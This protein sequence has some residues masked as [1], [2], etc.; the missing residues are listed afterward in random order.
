[1]IDEV[2]RERGAADHRARRADDVA[3]LRRSASRARISA[4]TRR[5][6]SRCSRSLD[7]RGIRRAGRRR[8]RPGW[9]IRDGR[10]A[11]S[12]RRLAD[13]RE[14]LLDAAHNPAGA[15]ALASYLTDAGGGAAAARVRRDARQGRR[16][17]CSRALLPAVEPPRRHARVERALGRSGR[18]GATGARDRAGAADRDRAG[19]RRRARRRVARSRRASS[20]PDRSSC[21]ATCMKSVDGT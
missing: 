4:R 19:A 13:G 7:A 11:S 1:M 6:P 10:A 21:S 8:S 20:S 12:V 5:S 3:R 9:R 18:A 17:A 15:A 16:A 14:L 2:A